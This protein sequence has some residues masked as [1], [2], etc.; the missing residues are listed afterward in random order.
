MSLLKKVKK[1]G[2]IGS[3]KLAPSKIAQILNDVIYYIC[4]VFPIDDNL[5]IFESEG[6]LCDNAFALY[7]YM[8]QNGY[9]DKYKVIWLVDNVEEAKKN[10]WPNT[11]FVKKIPKNIQLKRSKYLATCKYFIFDHCNILSPLHKRKDCYVLNLWHGCGFKGNNDIKYNEII[12]WPNKTLVT[13]KFFIPQFEAI[14]RYKQEDILDFG[15]PRNQYLFKNDNDGQTK[16]IKDLK[17][18]NFYKVIFWMPTFRRSWN[19]SIDEK[20]FSSQTGLPIIENAELLNKF[21]DYL[22]SLNVLCIFKLHHLQSQ[23]N[24]FKEEYSNIRILKDEEIREYRLQ[25]YQIL[26]L[27]D[28]L[29][30]DYSSIST[31]YLLLDRPI[32]FTTDDYDEYKESRSFV[33]ENSIDYFAGYCVNTY[34]ELIEAVNEINE[35]KDKFKNKRYKMLEIMQTYKDGNAS[36]RIL[37]YLNL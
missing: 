14:F 5:I 26:P 12:T 6:D 33:P 20:Y 31:D 35:G 9:L 34:K 32:I 16:I 37:D 36:Q 11:D 27:A 15:Y 7:D 2:I 8:M 4:W 22:K 10:N 18:K 28:Y 30:T 19:K 29:I 3:I 21:N 23:L 17:L 1:H 25:L 13:G 24:L